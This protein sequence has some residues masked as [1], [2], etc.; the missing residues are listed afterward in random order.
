MT[1]TS[2]RIEDLEK[3]L[4]GMKKLLKDSEQKTENSRK[5]LDSGRSISFHFESGNKIERVNA[6]SS[7]RFTNREQRNSN[8]VE[9]SD[10]P[11]MKN[12][13]GQ[14]FKGI[15]SALWKSK[16]EGLKNGKASGNESM[17]RNQRCSVVDE[18]DVSPPSIWDFD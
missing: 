12:N 16:N 5:V 9:N 6:P 18:E 1:T 10:T 2:S 8:S 11:R 3:Q 15:K 4:Q 13:L 7:F 17:R 14:W